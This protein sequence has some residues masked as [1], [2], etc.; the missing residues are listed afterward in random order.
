M[1]IEELIKD[2]VNIDMNHCRARSTKNCLCLEEFV[3]KHSWMNENLGTPEDALKLLKG[4]RR[5]A[6][7]LSNE[8]CTRN[9]IK[10][11]NGDGERSNS[12]CFR[13]RKSKKYVQYIF[14]TRRKLRSHGICEIAAKKI[15]KYSSNIIY[16][17]L[18]HDSENRNDLIFD[19]KRR[20]KPN[21]KHIQIQELME[22]RCCKNKCTNKLKNDVTYYSKLRSDAKISLKMKREAI[23]KLLMTPS[24]E[25]P[26]C[27]KFIVFFLGVSNATISSLRNMLGLGSKGVKKQES[28]QTDEKPA[29][30]IQNLE[31]TMPVQT[32]NT[33]HQT[34]N[35]DKNFFQ[36]YPIPQD[37]WQ[38]S[39]SFQNNEVPTTQTQQIFYPAKSFAE[40]HSNGYSLLMPEQLQTSV[41]M[42][43][44]ISIQGFPN[45]VNVSQQFYVSNE[46]VA[47][48]SHNP[49]IN[50]IGYTGKNAGNN[51][52]PTYNNNLTPQRNI[53][54]HQ[55]NQNL[56][57]DFSYQHLPTYPANVNRINTI[58]P[59]PIL[60]WNGK[61]ITTHTPLSFG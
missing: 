43:Q 29:A 11:G 4:L 40:L 5:E 23:T 19:E 47:S 51:I 24:D 21:K 37:M 17:K 53:S 9:G 15:L 33:H 55:M 31:T 32:S 22:M 52:F 35:A 2:P 58:N 49:N 18:I 46:G 7:Q 39:V 59:S 42:N 27:S 50:Y 41:P 44:N 20:L 45:V 3:M 61:P 10:I 6:V 48:A 14:E 56:V 34:T 8:P 16:Q 54:I 13:Y 57:N 12:M 60:Y 26:N 36:V 28:E 25:I 30:Y 1:E 38:S